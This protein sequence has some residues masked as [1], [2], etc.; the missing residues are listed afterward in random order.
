MMGRRQSFTRRVLCDDP[1]TLIDLDEEQYNM[2]V[3]TTEL[4]Y[5]LNSMVTFNRLGNW[6]PSARCAEP[7]ADD[8]LLTAGLATFRSTLPKMVERWELFLR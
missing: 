5:G 8:E 4:Q 7:L 2:V 1:R 6:Q 3:L